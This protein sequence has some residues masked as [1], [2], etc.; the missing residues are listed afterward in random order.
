M[1]FTIRKYTDNDL[2]GVL[3]SWENATKI[4]HPFLAEE[5]L[6]KERYN[7]P[8][9]YIPNTETWVAEVEGKVIG[10]IALMGCEVGAI[11]LEPKFHGEGIGLALMNK[12]QEIH[13]TL[14]VEVFEENAIGRKFYDQYGFKL[15]KKY[16]HPETNRVVHRMKF[17]PG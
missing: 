3:S 9:V 5:F 10:F 12:A 1:A 4:A 15:I 16:V 14:E 17:V 7:I 2:K 13:G 8:N 11:F 6:E